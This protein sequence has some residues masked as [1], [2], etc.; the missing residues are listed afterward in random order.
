ME[1]GWGLVLPVLMAYVEKEIINNNNKN[2]ENNSKSFYSYTIANL[3]FTII[4]IVIDKIRLQNSS[5]LNKTKM[6]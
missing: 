4:A 2:K 5:R 1:V 3:Y 6:T